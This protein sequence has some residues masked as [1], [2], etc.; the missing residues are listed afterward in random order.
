MIFTAEKTKGKS[1]QVF[2][3]AGVQLTGVNRYDSKTR[4][5]TIYLTGINVYGKEKVLRKRLGGKKVAF[6]PFAVLKVKVKIP[7][8]TIVVDGVKY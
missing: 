3:A 8:S 7:G 5:A 4:E 2:D 6:G 1:V